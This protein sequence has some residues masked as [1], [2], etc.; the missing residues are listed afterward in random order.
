MNDCCLSDE[1][2]TNEVDDDGDDGMIV[3]IGNRATVYEV[4]ETE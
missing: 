1:L 3:L 2:Y 4:I